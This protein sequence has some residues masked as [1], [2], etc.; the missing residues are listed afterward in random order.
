MR[1]LLRG[2]RGESGRRLA[3]LLAEKSRREMPR[4]RSD[5]QSGWKSQARGPGQTTKRPKGKRSPSR[6]PQGRNQRSRFGPSRCFLHVSPRS[7]GSLWPELINNQGGEGRWGFILGHSPLRGACNCTLSY[8]T[9]TFHASQCMFYFKS[10]IVLKT[11]ENA[12][13]TL[14]NGP[15]FAL[16]TE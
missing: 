12:P 1:P 9:V 13:N 16:R 15:T 11:E 2:R 8:S 5:L 14:A 3:W 4:P 6:V 7:H 10:T